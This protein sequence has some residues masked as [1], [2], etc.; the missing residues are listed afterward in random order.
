MTDAAAGA[1]PSRQPLDEVMMAMDVVDTLRRRERL[2]LTELDDA[3]RRSELKERLKEIYEAQGIDVPDRIL[4]EGVSAL[5]ENRFVFDPPKNSLSVRLAH[6]Y[7]TRDRWEK[8]VLGGLAILLIA[9]AAN[10][11][12]VTRPN[13]QLGPELAGTRERITEMTRDPVALRS[14]DD[15]LRDGQAALGRDEIEAARAALASLR[16]L[17]SQLDQSYTLRVV[18]EPGELTGVWRVPEV[19]PNAQNY[20]IIV[21]AL[22]A[23]GQRLA[24]PVENEET[25]RVERVSIWG[26]RV[27]KSVFDAIAADKKDDGI[28]QDNV[29]GEKPRGVLMPAYNFPTTGDAITEW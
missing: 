23:S 16:D 14:A 27:D 12:M 2:V 17:Q 4:E 29:F 25:G 20:Y 3:K 19:N 1:A 8:W 18:N 28:I 21:E 6:L 24:V 7:V 26:L 5:T 22:G 9:L 15:L 13:S 11:A 10:Y